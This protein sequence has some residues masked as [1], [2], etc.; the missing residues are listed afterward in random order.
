MEPGKL[1]G[2]APLLL[3]R[4]AFLARMAAL[5]GA[6]MLLPH[7]TNGNTQAPIAGKL[8]GSGSEVGH[9][10][11]EG[12]FPSPQRTQKVSTLIIGGGVA[13]L[14]A[15]RQLK[16]VG[17]EFLLLD[18]ESETGGNARGG[19]NKISAYPW[20]A[21]YLPLPD[22]SL[23]ELIALLEENGT[24][25][26]RNAHGEPVYNELHLS[27]APQERL[28]INTRWQADLVPAYGLASDAKEQI[29]QFLK[30]MSQFRNATGT[31]G[32]K[33]FAIPL[34][35][36]STDENFRS[37][38]RITM[39]QWLAA[40]GFTAPE[41]IEY[42]NYCCRDDYGTTVNDTSA[43][44]GIHY[45]A[46][47]HGGGEAY[48]G[49]VITFPEGNARLI[50]T[51][52]KNI[53]AEIRTRQMATAVQINN[54]KVWVDVW[55]VA[56]NH[57]L[58]YEAAQVIMAMPQFIASKLLGGLRTINTSAFTYSP[59]MVANITT[60]EFQSNGNVPLSWDNVIHGS[61]ALGYVNAC[62]QQL[63]QPGN[64]YVFTFYMPL[65]HLPPAEARREASALTHSAW[66][67]L[68]IAE[69]GKA[70]PGVR[71]S[72]S[73]IDVW[74][75]GHGMIRPLPGFIWGDARRQAAGPLQNRIHFAHTDLS[76]ISIFEEAFYQGLQA[77]QAVLANLPHHA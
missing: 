36:S 24:V 56:A 54:D 40:Q 27:F 48:E 13:G 59:W 9:R 53:T 30:S 55:D 42:V 7:C 10:L 57:T 6:S 49:S 75:W 23:S 12:N 31:D 46:S 44:A 29:T 15:A 35:R 17:V 50:H 58:R 28:F 22:S 20:G 5:A 73:N 1:N 65:T 11:R 8:T 14:S 37:L 16:K 72:I 70:H 25:T 38:D 39:Q 43:W 77:A 4:S 61:K 76:G 21:H 18:L 47:R 63:Q 67:D 41:L 69:L 62:H 71:S 3:S 60:K 51:L 32:K 64:E 66:C 2:T 33:A 74:L 19:S 68:I 34:D 26:G 45:F 52:Q